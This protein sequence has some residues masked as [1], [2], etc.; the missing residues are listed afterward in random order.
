METFAATFLLGLGSAASPCLLPVYPAF[1]AYLAGGRSDERHGPG[2]A[3]LGLAVLAGLLTTMVVVGA[4][5]SLLAVPFGDLLRWSIPVTTVVLVALGLA[6]LWISP[7]CRSGPAMRGHLGSMDRGV[8]RPSIAYRPQPGTGPLVATSERQ[9]R[10]R[11]ED[12]RQLVV[13]MVCVIALVVGA[14][15]GGIGGRTGTDPTATGTGTPATGAGAPASEHADPSPADTHLPLCNEIEPVSAPA[16]RYRSSPIYVANEQPTEMIRA[17]ASGKPGFEEI[18]IDREHLG[19]ITVAFSV[20]AAARQ[21]ELEERFPDVGVVAV[22]VEWRKAD[23]KEVQR[24]VMDEIGPLFPVSSGISVTQGVVTV[25]IGVL[26]KDRVAAIAERFAGEPLC[27]EG[28]DPA[29]VPAE[30]PQ[31]QAGDG[32]RLLADEQGVGEAYRTGIA[33]DRASYERLWADVGLAAEPKAVDFETEVIIWFGAVYGSSCPR[34]RLDDVVV[35]QER[36]L[37]HAEIVLVGAPMACT[38]DA[39]P[40]AYLVALDRAKLPSGPFAIQLGADDPP[41][42]VPEERTVV[43]VDLSRPGAVA[44]RGDVHGDPSLPEPFVLEYGSFMEPGIEYPYRL[45]VHC[46]IEWLGRFNDVAWRADV[47]DDVLDLVPPD[48][49]TAVDADQTIELTIVLRTDPKP[50]IEATANGHTVIYRPTTEEPPG[51]D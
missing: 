37:V 17:W 4:F 46:G 2:N 16:E 20:D 48:W 27:I 1:I 9:G 5:L 3:L 19:W 13:V 22:E 49:H 26:K 23:L 29:D 12:M 35:D 45:F 42:G 7:F 10:S 44:G 6:L 14:C 40:Q 43:D 28:A 50:V 41:A 32:W 11:G 33:S 30:G 21:A 15:G 36:A 47:P 51:C 34:L 24:R 39:N 38:D 25:A 31:A 18:W 8:D